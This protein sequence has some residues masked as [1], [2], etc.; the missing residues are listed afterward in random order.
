MKKMKWTASL[1]LI[2]ALA[3]SMTVTASAASQYKV[4][5]S[6]GL[7]GDQETIAYVDAGDP[8]TPPT[9]ADN[10]KYYWKGYHIA[11]QDDVQ[12]TF[13]VDRD[14][15][16][17][18][19]Y[20]M[21][22]TMV[23][24]T[25][26]YVE[27]GTTNVLHAPQTFYGNKNDTPV[28]SYVYIEGYEPQAYNIT[29]TLKEGTNDW[30]LYYYKIVTP[31]AAPDE[32]AGG[33]GGGGGGNANANA[34]ANANV[35][36]GD[37]IVNQ[38]GNANAGVQQQPQE[39]INVDEPTAPLAGPNGEGEPSASPG[40]EATLDPNTAAGKNAENMKLGTLFAAIGGASA[41]TILLGLLIA[42]FKKGLFG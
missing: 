16:L 29:G 12:K 27:Y 37:I 32:N 39:I 3:L 15:V 9:Q 6:K 28:S 42:I 8:Y 30:T 23:S 1:I 2:L 10:G 21:K 17:V 41:L 33:G 19:S 24:Y 14:M 25:I 26:H 7:Y 5:V 22:G 34:N 31:T 40:A 13:T 11:G 4:T 18:A 38:G 20:G 35:P 36:G